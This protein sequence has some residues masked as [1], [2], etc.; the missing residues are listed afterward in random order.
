MSANRDQSLDGYVEHYLKTGHNALPWVTYD[1]GPVVSV[2]LQ[3]VP[4][5]Q[6]ELF[7][8]KPG[9]GFPRA[10]RHP[11]VDSVEFVVSE[12][13]P[14]FVNGRDITRVDGMRERLTNYG[15]KYPVRAEDWHAV[16]DVPNGGSFLS[17]QKW[18]NGV[19]PTSVGKNWEGCPVS[20][21][22]KTLLREPDSVW[23][24]TVHKE[25][26]NA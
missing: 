4:P 23:I 14:F 26:A 16:G 6:A 8:L 21:Q 12:Y 22:H 19:E 10:H 3:R 18:K 15:A 5:F 20:Q 7:I 1:F 17:L 13:I 2:V 24:K 11:D 9:L 25:N